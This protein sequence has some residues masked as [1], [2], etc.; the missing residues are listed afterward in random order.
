[1]M[2]WLIQTAT[3]AVCTSAIQH[4]MTQKFCCIVAVRT[5]TIQ[6]QYKFFT[7]AANSLQVFCKL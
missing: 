5:S 4:N 3:K 6:L 7:T 2:S 1:M